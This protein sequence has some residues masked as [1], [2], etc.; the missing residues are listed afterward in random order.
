MVVVVVIIII[1]IILLQL[2]IPPSTDSMEKANIRNLG[3]K[4]GG[5]CAVR[6]VRLKEC[7]IGIKGSMNVG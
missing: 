7:I 5:T 2:P 1:I 6:A 3:W 4:S